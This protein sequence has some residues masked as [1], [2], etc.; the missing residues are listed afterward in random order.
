MKLSESSSVILRS[1]VFGRHMCF[2]HIRD[3]IRESQLGASPFMIGFLMF[4]DRHRKGGNLKMP[5]IPARSRQ[6]RSRL[7]SHQLMYSRICVQPPPGT[8]RSRAELIAWR[9]LVWTC[10]GG[11]VQRIQRSDCTNNCSVA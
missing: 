8:W 7:A 1:F 11:D 4:P 6:E 2:S 3:R 5:H 10:L 9:E